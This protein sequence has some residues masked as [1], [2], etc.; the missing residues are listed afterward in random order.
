MEVLL[1]VPLHCWHLPEQG[2]ASAEV[3]VLCSCGAMV[4]LWIS[5]YDRAG[6]GHINK[7]VLNTAQQL[8]CSLGCGIDR[9]PTY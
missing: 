2:I 4:V 3:T 9:V 7:G 6:I 5:S 8:G 1:Y